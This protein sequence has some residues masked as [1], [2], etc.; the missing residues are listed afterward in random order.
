MAKAGNS[1]RRI[2]SWVL[3]ALASTSF[4][5]LATAVPADAHTPA[6]DGRRHESAAGA[7]VFSDPNLSQVAYQDMAGTSRFW[8]A[9]DLAAGQSLSVQLGKP[10]LERLGD[11]HPSLALV[12][13]GL[14]SDSVPFALPAGAGA[15][16]VAPD[17]QPQPFDEPFTGTSDLIL[18][19]ATI[20][21]PATG[22]FYVVAFGPADA[23]GKLFVVVGTQERFGLAEVIAYHDTLIGVRAFHEISAT[24]LPP[25]P[26]TLDFFSLVLRSLYPNYP[27]PA[28]SMWP[29]PR[30]PA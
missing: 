16:V 21:A 5:V 22:R 18:A 4:V 27:R 11:Y 8:V 29:S 2:G 3:T 1:R 24:P 23:H 13:P 19:T 7:L 20:A 28:T 10:A 6:Q 15:T 26:A 17:G 25:L 12:G 9:V 14:G 30:Q